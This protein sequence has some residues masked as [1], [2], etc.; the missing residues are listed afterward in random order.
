MRITVITVG[1]LKEKYF[2]AA[3][4]EYEKR[5]GAWCKPEIREVEPARLP[6]SPSGAEIEKALQTEASKIERF[7]PSPAAVI[8]L[9]IEGKMLSSEELCERI[10]K[11]QLSGVSHL[12]FI[13]GGSYGLSPSL[14]ARADLKLSMSPMT[15][16]HRLARVMLLEQIYRAFKISE[17]STYHK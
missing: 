7:L 1:K 13:I 3:S 10:E 2:A 4:E 15:F 17:G 11:W 6:E 9:C 14:K 16:P 8:A 5:L 12:C